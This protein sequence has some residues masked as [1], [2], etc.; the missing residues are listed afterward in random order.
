MSYSRPKTCV[1]RGRP[2]QKKLSMGWIIPLVQMPTLF[3]YISHAKSK[4]LTLREKRRRRRRKYWERG[5]VKRLLTSWLTPLRHSLLTHHFPS[6]SMLLTPSSSSLYLDLRLT[7][8]LSFLPLLP[9]CI[10]FTVLYL[11]S[12]CKILLSLFSSFASLSIH[13]SSGSSSYWGG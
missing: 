12:L 8:S 3:F 5:G 6:L 1:P 2:C 7:F 4:F 13:L 10:R 9:R 11:S